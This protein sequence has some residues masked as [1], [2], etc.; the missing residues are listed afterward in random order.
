MAVLFAFLFLASL[1]VWVGSIVFFSFFATPAVL[2]TSPPAAALR[3]AA[4]MTL[5]YL[6]LGW[7]CGG[8]AMV[9]VLLLPP[10]EGLYSAT[11]IVLV[12]VMF[13][14]SLY[15][16]FDIGARVKQVE[17][18]VNGAEGDDVPKSAVQEFESVRDVAG[19]LNGS[20]LL[21]GAIV[22]FI[23]AFYG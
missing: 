15:L 5:S 10:I 16:A 14:I 23:T 6:K 18:A 17:E 12:A 2:L 21:L 22:V 13:L 7:I 11:R 20:L 1:T 3:V 8:I 4:P 9:S 19:Q